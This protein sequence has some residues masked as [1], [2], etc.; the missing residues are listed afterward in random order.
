M[1]TTL[2]GPTYPPL[3][4]LLD[5]AAFHAMGGTHVVTLHVQF[6]FFT[7]GF[8]AALAGV[9]AP[10]ARPWLLW[11]ALLLLLVVPRTNERLFTPQADFLV[12]Y[13][14]VLAAVLL[15]LWLD[16][17]DRWRLVAITVLLSGAVLTKREGVLFAACLL[18]AALAA[19]VRR[20]RVAWP[21]LL[22]IGGVVVACGV[23]WRLWYR[24][25]GIGGEAPPGGGA[26][27]SLSRAA[28]AVRLSLDVL[29]DNGL[30]SVV[31]MVGVIAIALAL[32]WGR[33]AQGVFALGLLTLI[34][35]GGAWIT[36]AYTELPVTANEA[37][38]P[39]V[40]YTAAE[41]ILLACLA[42]VLL[43]QVWRRAE[44]LQR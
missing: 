30:W 16:L 3:V 40:R 4:P 1:F 12:D 23:P 41:V 43:E 2:P 5:A 20:R 44:V 21:P 38:N 17:G 8:V 18:V 35:L 11:P 9:L 36:T 37:L 10:H 28:D 26:E 34:V 39:I 42:P 31:P 13:F 24:A 33:R 25:H 29:F 32:V 22:L 6:W 7:L 14:F 15:V 19:T 27:S